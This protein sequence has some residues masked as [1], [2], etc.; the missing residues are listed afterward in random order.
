[1]NLSDENKQEI[2]RQ[3][4][5]LIGQ[6]LFLMSTREH[7]DNDYRFRPPYE[8]DYSR[9][10]YSSAFRRLQ[11]KMQILGVNSAAFFRN[12]LT[13]SLEVSQVACAIA[14]LLA[15]QCNRQSMY[16]KD[17]EF[18]IMAAALA[19][20][21]GHPAFGHKGERVLDKLCRSL[22][23]P[24]RFEGNA[25]NFRVLRTLEKKEAS[26]KGLNLTNRTLLAINKYLVLESNEVVD[27]KPVVK[28]F[29]YAEDYNYLESV[30]EKANLQKQRTLDVQIIDLADEI[31]YAVHDLEDGLA[32][33]SF[34]IDELLYELQNFKDGL[35]KNDEGFAL[36]Q[37][38]VEES[39]QEAFTAKDY[40][41]LQEYSQVFRKDLT[42]RLTHALIN[43]LTVRKVGEKFAKEHGVNADN[44]ELTL[45]IFGNLREAL[46]K[47]IFKCISREPHIE[48]Y[49]SRGNKVISRLYGLFDKNPHLLTPDYRCEEDSHQQSRLIVDFIAGMMDT[50]AIAQYETYFKEKFDEIDISDDFSLTQM[51]YKH[52]DTQRILRYLQQH[53]EGTTVDA[54]LQYSGAD[55]LRVYPALFELEQ[56][57]QLEVLER[58]ELGAPRIVRWIQTD[59]HGNNE[60]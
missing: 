51:D 23:K 22:E 6:N 50:F 9:V 15:K 33:H 4:D 27:G 47:V 36:F 34:G 20:D 26:I 46:T 1:M 41:T 60:K 2:K 59:E 31:A 45:D 57:G 16:T 53:K 21:I 49:E 38:M 12:R 11:G 48:L 14:R 28:K 18:V 29:L 17:E 43:D 10:L 3:Y 56:A 42:S 52:L 32:L 24:F 58:E 37:K 5:L 44:Q 55:K 25:Q 30:R 40:K 19:H 8:R 7:G 39:R 35:L 13:H 54:I